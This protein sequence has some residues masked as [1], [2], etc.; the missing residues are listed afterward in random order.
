MSKNRTQIQEQLKPI[1]CYGCDCHPYESLED[2][3]KYE[4]QKIEIGA[5][6]TIRCTGKEC[7][8][9]AINRGGHIDVFVEPYDC[10]RCNQNVHKQNLIKRK[11]NDTRI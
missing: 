9:T 5:K 8:V 11:E 3:K 6:Y 7:I 4:N 2:L 1:G 10:P